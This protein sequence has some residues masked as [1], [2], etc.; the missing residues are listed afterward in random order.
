MAFMAQDKLNVG[1]LR[2]LIL[3][4]LQKK[5]GQSS[6][7]VNSQQS[8]VKYPKQTIMLG[9]SFSARVFIAGVDTNQLPKFTLYKYDSQGN[10]LD[11]VPYDTFRMMEVKGLFATKPTKQ[12][13][14]YFGGDIIIQ[15]EEG[16][17]VILLNKSIE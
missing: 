14:Y 15:S 10:R 11:S 8:V 16:E 5:T 1:N 6:I 7:T 13:T 17:K 9:D 3:E 4:L 2:V 12:G